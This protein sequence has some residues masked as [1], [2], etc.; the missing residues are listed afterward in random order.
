MAGGKVGKVALVG[1]QSATAQS[2]SRRNRLAAVQTQ[3]YIGGRQEEEP[4]KWRSMMRK[5]QT[6]I[7]FIIA[8]FLACSSPLVQETKEQTARKRPVRKISITGE[9]AKAEHGYIIRGKVPSAIFT[10]LNPDPNKLDEFVKSEKIVLIET[11]IVSGD[12]VEIEKIDG[13]EYR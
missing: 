13:K 4:L 12:N 3:T 10:I 5:R 2:V 9:I 11:R 8:I 6:F 7:L 1:P